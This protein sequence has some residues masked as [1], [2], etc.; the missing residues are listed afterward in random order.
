MKL[1]GQWAILF[2][3]V[4]VCM[5][6]LPYIS[7]AFNTPRGHPV[8]PL[9]DAYI[10]FQYARQIALGQPYAYNVGDP[11]TTGMTS[12][13]F[14]FLLAGVYLLGFTGESLPAFAVGSGVIW[15]ALTAWLTTRLVLRLVDEAT[16][17]LWPWAAAVLVTLTGAVQWGCFNGMETGLFTVLTLAAL[18]AFFAKRTEWCVLWLGLASLTRPE[19][20]LLAGLIWAISLLDSYFKMHS[21]N[22]KRQLPLTAA[23]LV[24]FVPMAVNW[25]LTG[26]SS[27]AGLLAKSWFYNAPFNLGDILR[28]IGLSYRRL[29]MER[30]LG[31]GELGLWFVTPGFLLFLFL[32]GVVLWKHR[33][34]EQC[35]LLAL[36]FLGGTFTAATLITT[37]WHLGR[38]QVP[39]IPVGMA[40]IVYGLAAL[41]GQT[42]RRWQQVLLG[43]VVLMMLALSTYSTLHFSNIYRRAIRT[44]VRQQLAI[45]DWLRDNLPSDARVGVH[46][47]GSLRYIGE[48]PTYDLIGLTTAHAAIP[49]RNGSGSVYELMEHSP[50]RPEYFAIYPDAFSIPYLAN[51]DLF[52]EELFSVN[53]PDYAIASA[54]PVQGV[55]RAD[56]HLADSGVQIYQP[57]VAKQIMG[58]AL[59]DSLDV[60]DLDDE[61]AHNVEW[62]HNLQR[63]GFPTDVL[64]MTYRVLPEQ[65]V[66]DGG[67]LLSGGISF[68]VET[69]PHESLWLVA[70]L[71]ALEAGSVRVEVNE[72]VVGDWA[73][74]PVPGQWLE[75]VFQIP[76]DII[77][78]SRSHITLHADLDSVEAAHYAPYYFWF[79]QGKHTLIPVEIENPVTVHFGGELSLLGFNMPED[80]WHPG[81]VVPIT[82]IW[83]A[84]APSQS[85]AKVFVHLYDDQ[86]HLWAQS[87]SWAFQGTRPPYTWHVNEAVT[88]PHLVV[89]PANLPLG[90]YS[91][92]AGLYT[93]E[94]GERLHAYLDGVR[95]NE[96]R[97]MLAVMHIEK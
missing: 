38:Y 3:L 12:P 4:I 5:V 83:Q 73:Y 94:N 57:D 65:E 40:M 76:A 10:T 70:R 96:E 67:R 71:H 62:W 48:R 36:W 2:L 44:M 68:D 34:R 28:S 58:L 18:E 46:D 21:V 69:R 80:H 75:T 60:A 32:S 86:G 7:A 52:T 29:L 31:I 78:S 63:P 64:Q 59:V 8:A 20:Q 90:I 39:F 27:A 91:I 11:P 88:D 51:T 55:W 35:A 82:L 16:T 22:W 47:T 42:K 92:E 9:D 54:G 24:G 1:T 17:G 13:L 61:T 30:F 45:A 50:M 56:W 97:V 66:L 77:N 19:G 23:V 84:S 33:K 93:P 74:P 85:D 89:L 14:G 53:V 37:T 41:Y 6:S 79:M 15:L 87:D 95:Q 81:D 26:E 43:I 25:Q 72:R 49:W